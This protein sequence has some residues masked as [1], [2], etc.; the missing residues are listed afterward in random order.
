MSPHDYSNDDSGFKEDMHQKRRYFEELRGKKSDRTLLRERDKAFRQVDRL[1]K[2]RLKMKDPGGGP[3]KRKAELLNPPRKAKIKQT[4]NPR[5]N[6][7]EHFVSNC[8]RLDASARYQETYLKFSPLKRAAKNHNMATAKVFHYD[9][10]MRQWSLVDQ[11]GYNARDGYLWVRAY[12]RGIYVA[13][14]LPK[15]AAE[16]RALAL[17]RFVYLNMRFG[18]MEGVVS[19]AADY[20]DEQAFEQLLHQSAQA[21]GKDTR[22]DVIERSRKLYRE[23]KAF[24]RDWPRQLPNNGLPEWHLLEFFEDQNK[25]IIH[26]YR[27]GDILDHLPHLEFLVQRVGRWYSLGPWNVNGRIKSLVIHPTSSNILYAGSAKGGVWKTTNA[28]ESWKHLW[29]FEESLAVGSLAISKSDPSTLYAA[30]GE[31]SPGWEPAGLGAGIYKTVNSGTSWTKVSPISEVG[32]RCAKIDIHP[33]NPNIVYVAT[34]T[35][36]HKTTDGGGDWNP[37]L[38]AGPASDLMIDPSNPQTIYAG[39]Q[40]IGIYKTTD[41]GD[42]WD[43]ISGSIV[44]HPLLFLFFGLMA[45]FP[46]NSE[47]GWIKL[48]MGRNGDNG[49]AFIVAKM[50]QNGEKLLASGNGGETW[51]PLPA[52]EQVKYNEWCTLVSVNPDDHRWIHAGGRGL[53]YTVNGFVFKKTSGTHADHHV[54]VYDPN[55]SNICYVATDGGVFK[56]TD[57]GINWTLKSRYLTATQLMSLGVSDKGS[58]LAGSATQDEGII[59][60]EG[61]YDWDDFGGGNEWG[62]YVVDPNDC[63]NL[64]I[65]PGDGELRRSK[66]KGRNYTT[67]RDNTLTD[68]WSSQDKQTRAARWRDV[69]VRPGNSQV[70]VGVAYVKDEIKNS[71]DVVTDSYSSRERIYFSSNQGDSWSIALDFSSGKGTCVGFAPNDGNRVYAATSDGQVFRSIN[72][73]QSG[74]V[75][76]YAEADKPPAGVITSI[77]VNHLDK[78]TVYITYGDANP[79]VYRSV[80]GGITWNSVS[81]ASSGTALPNVLVTSLVIDPEND[82]ILYVGTEIGVFRSNDAGTSWYFYNDSIGEY[83]LPRVMVTGLAIHK[84]TRRL[85]ASTMGR[86]LYY[87][88]VSGLDSMRVLEISKHFR[89]VEFTGIQYLKVTD[90]MTITIMSRWDVIR[91][92]EAGTNFYTIGADGSRAEGLY[93]QPDDQHPQ[94]Y[95]KTAPDAT[96]ADNLLSLP[97]FFHH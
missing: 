92:I 22:I 37:I 6:D 97:R 65:S 7:T 32:E 75:K 39:I 88:Y 13:I 90:G 30:T 47:A 96:Q 66:D 20:F 28:G 94:D 76:P 33:T 54:M 93:M 49:T 60:T 80:D 83:D 11:S 71:N 40:D 85:F 68:Y 9:A 86:G 58:F 82:D 50:G 72:G 36:V 51:Y 87:T 35:G 16:V 44:F 95:L 5:P 27:I 59:Q 18:K 91:R 61:S 79:H 17:K 2:S 34:N 26:A 70:L 19:R 25:K 10:R 81:G 1:R 4:D 15:N 8:Y 77:T 29:K 89:G 23:S 69:A 3:L 73:G 38:P 52:T 43:R 63:N 56:S 78:D 55:D 24:E 64:Y 12:R 14:A 21:A 62:M 84:P 31:F 48:A 45:D 74:W 57:R 53:S 46:E 67:L 41:G 42:H